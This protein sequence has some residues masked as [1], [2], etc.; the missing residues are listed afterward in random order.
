ML[1]GSSQPGSPGVYPITITANNGVPPASTQ[2]V[3]VLVTL[4]GDVDN[5]GVVNCT[6]LSLL[7]AAFG[8]YRGMANYDPRADINADGVVNILD[9]ALLSSK[10]PAGTKCQ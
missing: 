10:L 8:S 9:Q 1:S 5:N 3:L 7:K 2:N 6:D 4:V